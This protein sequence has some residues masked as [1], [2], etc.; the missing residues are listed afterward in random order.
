[1]FVHNNFGG[2]VPAMNLT[3]EDKNFIALINKELKTYIDDLE[4]MRLDSQNRSSLQMQTYFRLSLVS[5]GSSDSRKYV[6]V[7]RRARTRSAS[8]S[9]NPCFISPHYSLAFYIYTFLKRF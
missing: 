8:F 9:S 3:E 4:K 1:M 7:C 6:S 5:G 2:A